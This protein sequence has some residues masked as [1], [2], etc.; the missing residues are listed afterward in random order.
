[1]V[2]QLLAEGLACVVG[3]LIISAAANIPG[4][5]N[6]VSGGGDWNTTIGVDAF[7][8]F[9]YSSVLNNPIPQ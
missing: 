2:A 4:K 9:T 1:M 3:C 5:F 8:A 6:M 7:N